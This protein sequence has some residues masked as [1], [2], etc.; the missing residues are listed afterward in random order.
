[1]AIA[2]DA[3]SGGSSTNGTD[4]SLTV[5]HTVTGSNAILVVQMGTIVN[6]PGSEVLTGITYGGTALTQ[7]AKV[8]SGTLVSP[9]FQDCWT[10]LYYLANAPAGT[11]NIV[12]SFTAG[13]SNTLSAESLTGTATTSPI[14][15]SNTGSTT[16]GSTLTVS[17]TTVTD[18]CWTV[19]GYAGFQALSSSSGMSL[20]DQQPASHRSGIGDSNGVIH[21]AGSTSMSVTESGNGYP[22]LVVAAVKPFVAPPNSNFLTFF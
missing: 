8:Q 16:D 1:M 11:A 3:S 19:G 20:R 6:S 18:N 9:L 5:S 12:A 21:P 22:G 2:F 15:A 7:I 14:D 10:Y 13:G 17:V 4:T